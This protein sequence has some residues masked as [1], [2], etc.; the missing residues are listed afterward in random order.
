MSSIGNH[1]YID[2]DNEKTNNTNMILVIEFV[3]KLM[4]KR[5][6]IPD[7]L[8]KLQYS[9][10]NTKSIQRNQSIRKSETD[11]SKYNKILFIRESELISTIII[12]MKTSNI[13]R[14]DIGTICNKNQKYRTK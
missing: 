8:W 9:T 3:A 1:L 13:R 4:Y 2:I 7:S 6:R 14:N 12:G 5:Q 10:Q 11:K